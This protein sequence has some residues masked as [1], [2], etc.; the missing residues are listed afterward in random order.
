[1]K[2]IIIIFPFFSLFEIYIKKKKEKKINTI[3]YKFYYCTIEYV[4]FY[5][6]HG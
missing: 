4:V 3:K 6:Y 1:M 2:K 5:I